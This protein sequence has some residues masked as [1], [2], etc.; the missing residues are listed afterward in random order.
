MCALLLKPHAHGEQRVAWYAKPVVGFFNIFNRGFEALGNGYAAGLPPRAHRGAGADRLW[1]HRR[2]RRISLHLDRPRASSDQDRGYLIV[3][4][5]LPPGSSMSR[6]EEVMTR[7]ADLVL[8]T[9]GVA[10]IVNIVGFSGATF[11]NART[12][13]PCS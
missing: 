5:Q 12:P 11:T 4:A 8:G 10:H 7:A 2:L 6:T 1:R 3:A 13:A 9:P